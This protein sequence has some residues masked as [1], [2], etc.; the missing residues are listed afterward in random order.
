M[1][2][3]PTPKLW[4]LWQSAIRQCYLTTETTQQLLRK[5][6]GP[7]MAPTP[8]RWQWFYSKSTDRV[9][10]KIDDKF[11]LYSILPNRRHLR[12][13][14]YILNDTQNNL[15]NDAEQTTITAHSN[16]VW[17]HGSQPS[18]HETI[19][20]TNITDLIKDNDLWAIHSFSCSDNGMALAKAILKGTAVAVCN[21]SYKDNFGTAG[22][23]LQQGNNQDSRITGANVTP[24]HPKEIN[25]YQS[26]LAGIL[27]IVIVAE[28]IV[29]FHDINEGTIELGCDCAS[30]ITA[31]FQHT[32]D[33]P[34][35]PHHDLIHEN[36]Q[37]LAVSNLH[38][39]FR[40]IR[41]HQEKH[42]SYHL[43]DM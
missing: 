39:K 3:C 18:T 40:H 33:T 25:P 30:G 28:S 26:E 7:W 22:F 14:K 36:R 23:V 24:G 10:Q 35:Q 41:G 21:G 6:L 1:Q 38:W 19:N 32:Y 13:P 11:Q 2:G 42:V 31:V 27:A 4:D 37:K 12:N 17:C 9:Y 15:P 8:P 43:L 5:P 34:K 16:F 29:A 20:P